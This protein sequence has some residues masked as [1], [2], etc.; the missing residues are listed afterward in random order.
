[1]RDCYAADR[2]PCR[3]EGLEAEQGT[4]EPFHRSMVLLPDVIEIFR[5][6][7]DETI[8]GSGRLQRQVETE[9]AKLFGAGPLLGHFIT[10]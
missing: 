8:K 7:N 5:V 4:R 6:A 3:P 2:T 9:F 1:M 10:L